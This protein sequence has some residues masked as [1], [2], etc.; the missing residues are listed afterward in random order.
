MAE[1]LRKRSAMHCFTFRGFPDICRM[2]DK[3]HKISWTE[4]LELLQKICDGS[5]IPVDWDREKQKLY[6]L[7]ET[8]ERSWTFRFPLPFPVPDREETLCSYVARVPAQPAPYLV[9]LLQA[10]HSALGFFEGGEVRQHKVIKK[11][12]VRGKGKAQ[13]GY[14]GS[15][16]KSKAGSRV[17]LANSVSFFEDINAKLREWDVNGEAERILVSCPVALRALWFGS[18]VAPPFAKDDPRLIKV[19]M[20][21]HKPDHEELLRVNRR[22]VAGYV[23][24]MGELWA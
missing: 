17:R 24:G 6:G 7:D 9:V 15:R 22:C 10:G 3:P 20:D 16:G 8:G 1:V 2:N 11:Y 18:K 14:L 5:E 12:M 21:I 13:I 23:E 4:S 19:P